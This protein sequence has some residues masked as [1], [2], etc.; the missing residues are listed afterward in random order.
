MAGDD[1]KPPKASGPSGSGGA[2]SSTDP[3]AATRVT[4]RT[5]KAARTKHIKA[6]YNAFKDAERLGSFAPE[7][8]N[9]NLVKFSSEVRAVLTN[10]NSRS[11]KV[12]DLTERITFEL[13][14]DLEQE[15]IDAYDKETDDFLFTLRS[16]TGKLSVL[17]DTYKPVNVT[18]L[19]VTQPGFTTST[20][21][22][23]PSPPQ[24]LNASANS[25][26]NQT[27]TRLNCVKL[28][29]LELQKFDGTLTKFQ[30]FWQGFNAA[31]HSND[32]L[33]G[34]QKFYYLR[35]KLTGDA[36][37]AIKGFAV[38][39]ENYSHVIEILT[40]RFGDKD[41]V[42]M[43]HCRE[44]S[45]LEEAHDDVKSLRKFFDKCELHLRSLQSLG[46]PLD[47]Y[48]VVSTISDRLPVHVLASMRLANNIT[49]WTAQLLRDKLDAYITAFE[50]SSK[51]VSST[52]KTEKKT[53]KSQAKRSDSVLPSV[54]DHTQQSSGTQKFF[55]PKSM[56]CVFCNT[57][58]HWSDDCKKFPT[59]AQRKSLVK[60]RCIKCFNTNH[61]SKDCRS[62]RV[63]L[64]CRKND[65]H[66]SLCWTKF[67]KGSTTEQA[68]A[69]LDTD[70][71]SDADSTLDADPAST[72]TLYAGDERSFLA[73]A[74]CNISVPS[75]KRNLRCQAL[76]DL[77]S[78]CSYLTEDF[79]KKLGIKSK[80]FQTIN[81]ATFGQ[82]SIKQISCFLA[83]IHLIT[84]N[85]VRLPLTVRVVKEIAPK[86]TQQVLPEKIAR[87]LNR[88]Y[89]QDLADHY[90]TQSTRV[91]YCDMLIGCDY[92]FQL[93]LPKK[94]T[95]ATGLY[96]FWS[97]LGWL[98]SGRLPCEP[99]TTRLVPEHKTCM[100][101]IEPGLSTDGLASLDTGNVQY[102][103]TP[104]VLSQCD[105]SFNCFEYCA[106]SQCVIPDSIHADV[107]LASFDHK[108]KPITSP[109][110]LDI[111]RF[112]KLDLIGISDSAVDLGDLE[113]MRNFKNTITFRDG[114]Y[115]VS[116]PWRK[117]Q[118]VLPSN[119]GLALGSFSSCLKRL[120]NEPEL[121]R[122]YNDVL[123]EQL[124][125]G[126]I[127]IVDD[128]IETGR[129][130]H[131]IPHHPVLTPQKLST[132][133]RIVYN[134]SAKTSK[135]SCSLNDCLYRGPVLLPDLSGILLRFRLHPIAL[136][137]DIEKAFLNVG[138]HPPDRDVTRFFWIK[139]INNPVITPDNLLV[140]RFK[141]VAFGI[142]SSPFILSGTVRH[143][144]E[145]VAK[146]K[147]SYGD[148]ILND[149]YVDNVV[150]GVNTIDEAHEFYKQSKEAFF[151]AGFNL[152]EWN[153]NDQTFLSNLPSKDKV[154]QTEQKIMGMRWDTKTDSL[155]LAHNVKINMLDARTK[156]NVLSYLAMIF[157]PNGLYSPAIVDAKQFLAKLWH[158]KYGWDDP[159]GEDLI[160]E[161]QT[162]VNNM[163]YIFSINIPR[164]I[165][166]PFD[167]VTCD[168]VCFV[169]ASAKAYAAVIYLRQTH[170]NGTVT[171]HLIFSKMRLAPDGLSIPRMELLGLLI[172]ARALHFVR[173]Q[174]KLSVSSSILLCDSQCVLYWLKSRKAL[175][176]FVQNRVT[177]IKSFENMTFR[178]IPSE[179]NVADIATRVSPQTLDDYWF[180]GPEFLRQPVS[181]W[182]ISECTIVSSAE[183]KLAQSEI[184]DCEFSFDM[185]MMAVQNDTDQATVD[186][187]KSQSFVK[188][189]VKTNS[190][191][192]S[193]HD[194]PLQKF[195]SYNR[196]LRTTCYV[197]RA[198]RGFKRAGTGLNTRI[199]ANELYHAQV[200]WIK[201]I[202]RD[203]FNE[204]IV[205]TQ[206]RDLAPFYDDE[207]ILRCSGRLGN[208]N[209]YA[210]RRPILLPRKSHFTR[211]LIEHLH[212]ENFHVGTSQTLAILREKYWVPAGRAVVRQVLSQCTT[213][214]KFEGGPYIL[215]PMAE[216]P[217]NRVQESRAFDCTGLDYL[218][219]IVIKRIV[220]GEQTILSKAWVC[221]YT[222]FAVR[223]THLELITDLTSETFLQCFRRFIARRGLPSHVLSDNFSSFRLAKETIDEAFVN[224][225]QD[226]SANHGVEW[227]FITPLR[228]WSG[229][230]YERLVGLVK[231]CLRK[232]IGAKILEEHQFAT[233]LTEVERTLNSRPLL[234]VDSD[235]NSSFALTP[236]HFLG[237]TTFSSLPDIK[238]SD[239]TYSVSKPL[240]TERLLQIWL[241]GQKLLQQF[242][243]IW[244][245]EYIT[246]L[247][248]KHT[249]H[250]KQT[251]V[252]QNYIPQLND[253]VLLEENLPRGQWRLAK[254]VQLIPSN[255][256]QIRAVKIKTP[257][258]KILCRSPRCLFPIET[259]VS[260]DNDN[261]CDSIVPDSNDDN[262]ATT[263]QPPVKTRRQAAVS[264]RNFIRH[265][266]NQLLDDD[267]DG[268]SSST[269]RR[270]SSAKK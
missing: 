212:R 58:T 229:G 101:V 230:L 144:L 136:V 134:A 148:R 24:T 178:F 92:F 80:N 6:A 67:P 79:A 19:N 113:A 201:Q 204:A 184:K 90:C 23:H 128:T 60:N 165:Y 93:L 253:V 239:V 180:C 217:R 77:G 94:R 16:H 153:S 130:Q 158:L 245:A 75:S 264:A 186:N 242:W 268:D 65:H 112:W 258:G 262:D 83:T 119:Y 135:N 110:S 173:E 189:P 261:N 68:S 81:V 91:N 155:S 222:C 133:L 54:D 244:R 235:V 270:P 124:D 2:A 227:E 103:S 27:F 267:L 137:S 181:C 219:P 223:A 5:W 39:N 256:N 190:S 50:R 149:I 3:A 20:P 247:R 69:A 21:G 236:A 214:R 225:V 47:D 176:T 38:S 12:E 1:D 200:L 22:P 122:K 246:A 4:T 198:V 82:T 14:P 226:Y 216:M 30:E 192:I 109:E 9:Q 129:I 96:L 187:H 156:R 207:G 52:E 111:D 59:I 121:L 88:T 74:T 53:H 263:S 255:D 84:R 76:L 265:V 55:K 232:T 10:L 202:Q 40:K 194:I 163:Y 199:T 238:Q 218:G 169:D 237:L 26:S 87:Y 123:M 191:F 206:L 160:D 248:E 138:L 215:P 108:Q 260:V 197:I 62:S 18:G 72:S 170:K 162:V 48:F 100:L 7:D 41:T 182:P 177:E 127:E 145:N 252:K 161:W 43:Q 195:S 167:V 61:R 44:F 164:C 152:R 116:W 221:I 73:T 15:Q 105:P 114:R 143:H 57:S 139:D 174:L 78:Q 31:V 29:K 37:Q 46:H 70:E 210:S 259:S 34:V 64:Y 85:G 86:T 99:P 231:R 171:S 209:T 97:K 157:D 125:K 45:N 95:V 140:L 172:G 234:Y 33:D 213:C 166:S 36:L 126:I 196:L 269:P 56:H 254:V 120:S 151:T 142:V 107:S 51:V 147:L 205:R 146:E 32:Q 257:S 241:T 185:Q 150:S 13:D 17:L 132:K 266:T 66:R 211:L 243:K 106:M 8:I 89:G 11:D 208:L 168:L 188:N 28:P 25:Q 71:L 141:R 104:S 233:L 49:T 250:I 117:N 183:L 35:S 175:S 228:P 249:R 159:L 240:P 220:N 131:Y 224:S 102:F 154:Q 179:L 251:R 98:L 203:H 193:L 115:Y 118:D 63:C 42:I